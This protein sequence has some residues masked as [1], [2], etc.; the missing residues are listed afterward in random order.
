VLQHGEH[1]DLDLAHIASKPAV[2]TSY[3]TA[4]YTEKPR[5]RQRVS[6]RGQ[7][8][9]PS[10]QRNVSAIIAAIKPKAASQLTVPINSSIMRQASLLSAIAPDTGEG[11]KSTSVKKEPRRVGAGQDTLWSSFAHRPINA[12]SSPASSTGK[13]KAPAST[14]DD[15]ARLSG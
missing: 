6:L 1:F 12:C 5:R 9:L 8:R 7:F 14:A 15:G 3:P 10:R 11:A 4:A 13:E 2:P